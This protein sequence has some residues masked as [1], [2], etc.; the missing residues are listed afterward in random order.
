MFD[1]IMPIWE[2]YADHGYDGE[3]ILWLCVKLET[4]KYLCDWENAL[5]ENKYH[6]A[7]KRTPQMALAINRRYW[8]VGQS[9]FGVREQEVILN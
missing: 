3:S 5:M 7:V 8:W 9:T 1:E 2:V 6:E 4:A